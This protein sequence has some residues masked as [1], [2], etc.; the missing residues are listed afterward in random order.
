[1][2]RKLKGLAGI[3]IGSTEQELLS[4][5]GDP[6]E[7]QPLKDIPG[8]FL[9]YRGKNYSFELNEKGKVRSIKIIVPESFLT[10]ITN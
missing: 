10:Y 3:E 4:V 5:F 6:S 9:V 8:E 1:M 2:L 7:R